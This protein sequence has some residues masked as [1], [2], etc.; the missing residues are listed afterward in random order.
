MCES[1]LGYRR[2]IKIGKL[3]LR[4]L[5]WH[6][7]ICPLP[8]LVAGWGG[9]WL[10][11]AFVW[12]VWLLLLVLCGCSSLP[13]P[14]VR[15]P[16]FGLSAE[17]V[18]HTSLGSGL[19]QAQ[20]QQS[21]GLSGVFSLTEA[22]DA[23]A[24]RMLL[25]RYAERRLDVQYYIWRPDMTGL[26]LFEALHEAADRGVQVRL[27]LDDNNSLRSE[28]FLRALDQHPNIQVRLFNPFGQR[29][30]RWLNFVTDFTRANRRMHNKSFT[31]DGAVTIIGGRNVGDE[32]FG[33]ADDVLFADLDILA[34]GTVVG[35]V[36]TDF[37]RYWN[38]P[39]AYS[40]ADLPGRPRH[41]MDLEQLAQHSQAIANSQAAVQFL[42]SLREPQRLESLILHGEGLSWVPVRMVSDDPAKV[43]QRHAE[44]TLLLHQLQDIM[45]DPDKE[46]VLVS[47][48]FVPTAA[49][50]EAFAELAR[51]GVRVRVLT[52]S[53]AATDVSIVHAGYARHRKALLRSGV[54]LY[55]LASQQPQAPK[56]QLPGGK[57]RSWFAGSSGSSLHAKTF[58]FDRERVFVGSFNFDPRSA[59]L[60]TELGFVIDS[61]QLA[62]AIVGAFRHEVPALA[63][64]VR[65]QPDRRLSWRLDAYPQMSAQLREPGVSRWRR[66]KV[67]WLGRL[68]VE[69]LL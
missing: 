38:N 2:P 18:I 43:W 39:A 10:R 47:P 26:M 46:V 21:P 61:P 42:E 23:F 34:A 36:A 24:A 58:A 44:G 51:R 57:K 30:V 53:L 41:A 20:M 22:E 17:Q 31:A 60:N 67:W 54:E 19:A 48:Y 8:C 68:P 3:S 56:P 5:I 37:D 12:P 62:E 27:L 65:M 16:E 50:V 1:G 28:P 66:F 7:Y 69:P 45:G 33:A 55:E 14:V 49:G 13:Q 9:V 52:N 59:H 63:W 29:S 15:A 32:Y 4:L 64:R 25:A 6:K 35:E 40:V 11:T